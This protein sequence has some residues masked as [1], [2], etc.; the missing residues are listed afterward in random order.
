MSTRWEVCRSILPKTAEIPG[1]AV[2]EHP[3]QCPC[4]CDIALSGLAVSKVTSRFRLKDNESGSFTGA[5]DILS[6][7]S[8]YQCGERNQLPAEAALTASM[9]PLISTKD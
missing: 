5:E 6:L 3:S 4:P 9:S 7:A 1:A 2:S 8:W